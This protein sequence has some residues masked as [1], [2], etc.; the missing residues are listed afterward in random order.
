M[1]RLLSTIV[2]VV[3][4]AGAFA[5]PELRVEVPDVVAVNEQFNVTFVYEGE[6]RLSDFSWEPGNDFQLVWGPQTGRST[7][8]QTVNGKMTKSTQF[9]YTYVM[10]PKSAGKFSLPAA[11]AKVKG[12]SISSASVTVEVVSGGASSGDS[13]DASQG[14]RQAATG[15]VAEDDLFLR[16]TL[17]RTNVVV[18]EPVEATLKLYQRVNIAG[19]EDARFPTFNGFWSQEVEAPTN[20]EFKRESLDD[21]IYN[22]AILRKYV[23]IPQQTGT[24]S[25]DPAELVCL[26]N[27]RVSPK[28]GASIFDDFFGGGY[29]TVR[30]RVASSAMKVNVAPLPSGAPV[31]FRGGVGNYD[32]SA[33]LSKDS[34]HTHEAV[35]LVVTVSGRGNLSLLEAPKVTFPPDVEVYD[36][37][38]SEKTDRSGISGSKIYEYPFIP[39]SHGD[40]VIPSIQ[41]SYYDINAKRYVTKE[42]APITMSVAKGKESAGVGYTAPSAPLSGRTGVRSLNE[43][44]R[45]IYTK[46]PSFSS[47]GSFFV[48]SKGFWALTA[49]LVVLAVMLF[50]SF[51]KMAARRADIAGMKNRKATKMALKR[52][53]LAGDFLKRN[54]YTA[55]YEEL[56]KAMLGFASDKLNMAVGERSKERIA[57]EFT[58]RGVDGA[59]AERF[60]AIV[61]ACEFARYSPDAG[62]EAMERH[63]NEAVD[64]ISS[65][66]T[67]MKGR[68]GHAGKTA[69]MAL[70]LMLALPFGA[71]ASD[72]GSAPENAAADYSGKGGYVDDLWKNAVREYSEG[73]WEDA[74]A[75]FVNISE[76]GLESP[77]LYCNIGDAYFKGGDLPH[78]ILYYE[79]ALK[80]DPSYSDAKYN[81]GIAASLIKDRI[82][83]VPEFVLKSWTK[84]LC[85]ILDSDGWAVLFIV[86]LGLTLAMVLLFLLGTAVAARRAGFYSAIVFLLLAGVSLGFSLWQRTEY[87]KADS[88]IVMR[89]VSAVKSSPSAES[90]TDLFILHEGT[91]VGILDEVGDW[92]NIEL[93]DGRRG[94]M[95]IS[96]MEVI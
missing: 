82:D 73:K 61:D 13:R 5:Q 34:L 3:M 90:S 76:M 38:I 1:K 49:F 56:H 50:L 9:T 95:R 65:I 78:A 20:I 11:V 17:N 69:A 59:L 91:K 36:T 23:L 93:A 64:V 46:L 96:E 55:F 83:P 2:F 41:Y 25:I 68:K 88:A 51:R 32:I 77:E 12:K 14:G 71:I 19:F 29:T 84:S 75:S 87:M 57:E 89:P 62:H 74:I 70:A 85:Y 6:N 54:L 67:C 33:R 94:W 35:S 60:V 47:V 4:A 15:T 22:T 43:D 80:T 31:S 86:F 16:F 53:D 58:A 21:K 39:R 28:A 52:L 66:D 92:R 72:G 44:I 48:L 81:L 26:V 10:M 27:V 8:I 18:G 45:F 79:R 24:I 37:K 40:F 7:S 63:Y 30:K 42:T